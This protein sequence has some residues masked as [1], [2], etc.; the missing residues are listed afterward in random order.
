MNNIDL[1]VEDLV[2][3]A[4]RLEIAA[5]VLVGFSLGGVVAV[6]SAA[7][8][9]DRFGGLVAAG[10][11]IG[12]PGGRFLVGLFSAR[13]I[14]VGAIDLGAGVGGYARF[15]RT[16]AEDDP[17]LRPHAAWLA[18]EAGRT[19]PAYLHRLFRS[20]A[21]FDLTDVASRVRCPAAVVVTTEDE[22]VDPDSQRRLAAALGDGG[23]VSVHE[24]AGGHGAPIIQPERFDP[25][26]RAAVVSVLGGDRSKPP[27]PISQPDTTSGRS[28]VR[29]PGGD[30]PP[31]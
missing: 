19:D 20:M 5:P 14:A 28:P 17:V 18:A 11:P 29:R 24:V 10:T 3:V 23:L 30:P 2:A 22:T 25:V 26:L 8:R 16:V 21:G 4:D 13:S 1:L 7:A 9:P 12:A 15:L 6:A 27:S 31:T